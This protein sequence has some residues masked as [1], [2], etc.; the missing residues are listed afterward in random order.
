MPVYLLT[1]P[2]PRYS[3]WHAQPVT[4]ELEAVFSTLEE[5]LDAEERA[6]TRK[7]ATQ[8]RASADFPGIDPAPYLAASA[9]YNRI[10]A[11]LKVADIAVLAPYIET[12][13]SRFWDLQVA[14]HPH[15][16]PPIAYNTHN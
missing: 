12:A 9:E 16:N 6:Q 11:T 5:A 3:P 2:V 8:L 4:W 13:C 1:K 15:V 14:L 10:A 7:Y